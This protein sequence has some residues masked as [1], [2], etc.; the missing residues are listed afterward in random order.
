[1]EFVVDDWEQLVECTLVAIAP[2]AEQGRQ[3]V[4]GG[5]VAR[6]H[7]NR[8]C[9]CAFYCRATSGRSASLV[10]LHHKAHWRLG[11][12]KRIGERGA[13]PVSTPACALLRGGPTPC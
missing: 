5:G 2:R 4:V 7:R 9:P 3:V 1:M 12:R 8:W 13:L 6:V 11:S 10:L